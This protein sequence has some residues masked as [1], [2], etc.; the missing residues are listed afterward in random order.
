MSPPCK[1]MELRMVKGGG[2]KL[3]G[4]R[5]TMWVISYGMQLRLKRKYRLNL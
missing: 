2:S 3:A 4:D 1:N 5:S